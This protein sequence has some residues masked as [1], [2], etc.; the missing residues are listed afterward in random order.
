MELAERRA[1]VDPGSGQYATGYALAECSSGPKAQH[2]ALESV[3]DGPQGPDRIT[4]HRLGRATHHP[5]SVGLS[6]GLGLFVLWLLVG[7]LR[8]SN[9]GIEAEAVGG[10]VLVP[11][12]PR[13]SP[14]RRGALLPGGRAWS[15]RPGGV[16]RPVRGGPGAGL[17]DV[18]HE[19]SGD[20]RGLLQLRGAPVGDGQFPITDW[21]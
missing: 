11:I 6:F 17:R 19:D 4:R 3:P 1:R 20:G 2:P 18:R 13:Q 10:E 12:R 16:L 7:Y 15:I 9:V 5:R 8:A 21:T 14:F